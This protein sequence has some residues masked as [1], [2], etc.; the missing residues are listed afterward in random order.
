MFVIAVTE[1]ISIA[2]VIRRMG[3]SIV[4]SNYS[5]VKKHVE[6]LNLN[7]DHWKGQKHGTTIS[8]HKRDLLDLLTE[9]SVVNRSIIRKRIIRENTI[10]YNCN[11][12]G[13]IDWND[14]KLSFVLD[15]INGIPNDHRLEN[16][17]FLC[18]NCNSQTETFAGRN[19]K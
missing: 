8:S 19:K 3:R 15:H 6:R 2:G 13:I 11:I 1:E 7:T 5:W 12:C 4:G 18:P 14:K 9:N 16:L 17:R 10:P